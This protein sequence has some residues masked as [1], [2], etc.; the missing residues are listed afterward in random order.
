MRIDRLGAEHA[1]E[2]LTLQRAAYVTEARQL[3]DV[4]IGPLTQ[5][6]GELR[7]ELA[8]PA[9]IAMGGWLGHR[10]IAS[11]RVRIAGTRAEIARLAVAPDQRGRGY[12]M[13]ILLGCAPFLP[14]EV[15]EVWV[16]TSTDDT[17]VLAAYEDYGFER[18]FDEATD[19]L[20][21]AYL[22]KIVDRP[23]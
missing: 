22:R 23:V 13:E 8:D 9:V 5:T 15:S 3:G 12:S 17:Q 14:E 6:L 10:L 21:Q 18:Q 2:M 11:V 16:R 19:R 1:G 4:E 7:E 20:T